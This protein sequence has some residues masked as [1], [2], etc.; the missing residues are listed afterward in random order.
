MESGLYL[1]N[2]LLR[3]ADWAAMAHS[4]ELRV[5][6]VDANLRAALAAARFEPARTRGKA[7]LV[8]DLAP[9]LPPCIFEQEKRGFAVPGPDA[10]EQAR[11]VLR[12]F[13][14]HEELLQ[15]ERV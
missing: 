14:V 7:A 2:Q 15:A 11:R 5:P 9:E 8:R 3:D 10:R 1:R 13:A 12:G 6:L 4:L